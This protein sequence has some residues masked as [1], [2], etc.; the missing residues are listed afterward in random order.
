[1]KSKILRGMLL[2]ATLMWLAILGLPLAAHEAKAPA[3]TAGLGT[4]EFPTSA[5]SAQ[6][7]QAFVRAALLLHLFEYDEAAK[8]FQQA[9]SL[10][11]DFVM[12]VWGEAMTHNHPLWNQLDER[13]GRDV[14]AKLGKTPEERAAKAKTTRERDYLA[15]LEILYSGVGNKQERDL[16]YAAA[17]KE[18]AS[19]HPEDNQAQLFHALALLGRSE[20]VRNVPDYL[21]AAEISRR[22]F[23]KNPQNPGAAHYWIHG[24]DDPEHARGAIEPARALSKIAPDAG[25]AQHMTSHIFIA[26]G[27]WD[28]LVQAN[29]E[30]SRVVNEHAREQGKPQVSC[31]H[32]NEWLEYGYY[33]QGRMKDANALLLRCKQEGESALAASKPGKERDRLVARF[34]G[35]LPIMRATAVIESQDWN[36]PALQLDMPAIKDENVLAVDR[37]VTGFAAAQ[38]GDLTLARSVLAT[39]H[40]QVAAAKPDSENPQALDY[41]HI[42]HDDLAGLVAAKSG[43]MDTA[44]ALVRGAASRLDTMAFDFG[45]P[46]MVKPPHELLGELLLAVDRPGEAADA[47]TRSLQLAPLRSLSLLGLARAHKAAGHDVA[48]GAS[49]RQLLAIWHQADADLAILAEAHGK[50]P[51][52]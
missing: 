17:M 15:A 7:Q 16:L 23:E 47:F 25:H 4:L 20:G 51:S 43:D 2:L 13:A 9:Q 8:A 34:E 29:E 26:L 31:F 14:L 37:F 44:I 19:K 33:Q 35:S 3:P 39:L 40:D 46:V 12:A 24:M 50:V 11:P 27:L 32:Y 41:L 48:A 1:M 6:A 42:L 30:A 45:P 36:G 52:P 21:R 38:R 5:K 49:Y 28:D 22:I 10:E 18:L